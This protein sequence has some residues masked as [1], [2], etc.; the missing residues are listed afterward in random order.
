[1]IFSTLHQI[2]PEKLF[3]LSYPDLGLHKIKMIKSTLEKV[4]NKTHKKE[5][6][7]KY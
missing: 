5:K 4:E 3:L 1:M 7:K 2:S 6:R